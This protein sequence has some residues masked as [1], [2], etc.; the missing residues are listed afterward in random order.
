MRRHLSSSIQPFHEC[1]RM[2]GIYFNKLNFQLKLFKCSGE[3]K[4]FLC[5]NK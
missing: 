4:F 1:V 5:L 2:P 3:M